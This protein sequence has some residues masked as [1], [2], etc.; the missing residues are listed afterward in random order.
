MNKRRIIFF[1]KTSWKTNKDT[2]WK[3]KYARFVYCVMHTYS[4]ARKPYSSM[5]F[6]VATYNIGKKTPYSIQY[7]YTLAQPYKKH[8]YTNP[9]GSNR[10]PA[11][12]FPFLISLRSFKMSRSIKI[13]DHYYTNDSPTTWLH[14]LARVTLLLAACHLPS[15]ASAGLPRAL[16]RAPGASFSPVHVLFVV[17]T[18]R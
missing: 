18:D 2:R 12:T 10:L 6:N 1:K 7:T 8:T 9:K 3:R 13:I 5:P 4:P 16:A 14:V 11:P 15:R 17:I